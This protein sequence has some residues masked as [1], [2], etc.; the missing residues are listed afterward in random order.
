MTVT[1]QA[2]AAPAP[3]PA[4]ARRDVAE[5]GAK[6]V[7]DAMWTAGSWDRVEDGIASGSRAWIALAPLL[8]SGTDAC[9]S[10]G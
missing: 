10:E 2:V 8:S 1:C 5:H 6:A 4:S 9:T 3:T 7:V